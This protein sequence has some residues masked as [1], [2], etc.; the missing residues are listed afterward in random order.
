MSHRVAVIMGSESDWPTMEA[1]V[2]QL[3]QF[4]LEADVQ[5]LSAH[6]TPDKVADYA[7]SAAERGIS[8]IIAAAGMSAALPGSIAAHT[9]LPVIGVPMASGSLVG[10]DALLAISQMPPGVPVG[11]MA[12]GSPGAKNA[13]ILAAQILALSDPELR[14]KLAEHKRSMAESTDNTNRA[15][16]SRLAGQ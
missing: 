8:V 2:R 15:L 16:R 5:I 11:A 9:N 1:C 3:A 10:V 13:A 14:K 4:G 6:R 7:A 12:I